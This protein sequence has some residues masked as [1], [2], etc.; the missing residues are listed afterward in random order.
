MRS[1]PSLRSYLNV[2]IET[3][4]IFVC[5]TTALSRPFKEDLLALPFSRLSPPGDRWCDVLGFVP[6]GSVS[7]S[8]TIQIISICEGCFAR[9]SIPRSFSLTPACPGQYTHRSFRRWMSTIDTFH[10]SLFC[11]KLIGS[12]RMMASVVRC[13]L[14]RQSSVTA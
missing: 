2:A 9:Q 12:V 14:L 6:A 3:V 4:S 7:S 8:T 5:L 10:F 1:T 13:H 11:G